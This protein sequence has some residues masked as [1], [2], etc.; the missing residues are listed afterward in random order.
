MNNDTPDDDRTVAQP[1]PSTRPQPATAAPAPAGRSDS[2]NALPLGTYL[3][4]FELR[5]VA[6]EGG[7]SIVYRAW[8]H[9]LK[10]QVAV[11]E[12]FPSGMVGRSGGTQVVV[13]SERHTDAFEAGLKSFVEEA[14]LLAQFDHPA[15][16]KVYRFWKA[17][18]SAYM[19]MPFC[20]GITL[21]DDW[22]SKAE[23]P[24]ET[25]LMTLLDPLTEAL[26]VLHAERWYHR[27][28][29]PDNV[30]LLAG[31]RKPLLLDF[32]AARQV[33][34]D[35]THALTV[36]LK[37]GYAPI[38]QWGEVPGM[39]QGP[40]T[41]VY[42]LAATIHFGIMRRTPP[43]SV[44][45]LV[46]DGYQPL[47]QAAAGRYSDRFLAAVDHALAV[48]PELRTQTVHQFRDEIGLNEFSRD[49][50][51]TWMPA[52]GGAAT[53][54]PPATVPGAPATLIPDLELPTT[55]GPGQ[56]PPPSSGV[57]F[58]FSPQNAGELRTQPRTQPIAP[59]APSPSRSPVVLFAVGLV[60]TGVLGA[61]GYALLKPKPEPVAQTKPT[62]GAVAQSPT[63]AP[64]PAS[65]PPAAAAPVAVPPAPAPA[66]PAGF[67]AVADF[68]RIVA[69]KNS[70][71]AVELTLVRTTVRSEKDAVE[72][73]VRSN[74]DGYLYVL[75]HG[76]DGS[77]MQIYPNRKS[78]QIRVRKDV[79][80][81]LPRKADDELRIS[82]PSGS[83]QLLV[84]VS[85]HPRE[86]S[87]P[88]RVDGGYAFFQT[89]PAAEA[90]SAKHTGPQPWI[91]GKPKCANAD[92]CVDEFGAAVAVYSI[93]Q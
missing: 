71:H 83:N 73:T 45:R 33:I 8:D 3:D 23:A 27:D 57:E 44:G 74:Q 89:G 40:W 10:R 59:P 5:S 92:T 49:R 2:G 34:G 30:M 70:Q 93:V 66:P 63:P 6:G 60:V 46:N 69:A 64:A 62:T 85:K 17:N 76:S 38:E 56:E 55:G 26:G 52:T 91:A 86:M 11:K 81:D 35:M 53:T 67:N 58:T 29:A 80:L 9:S 4:E 16:I 21:R 28:I 65:T 15:L 87:P 18:G 82:G 37:P 72:F 68:N 19:V 14:R 47:A 25:A 61:G 88:A 32:G 77:L 79:A 51:M 41:D 12:Y 22:K 24:D 90:L 36:I 31:T 54:R 78:G 50:T 20:E 84:M 43:P 39:K 48:R 75:N 1:Q 13:R 42:A 7:F